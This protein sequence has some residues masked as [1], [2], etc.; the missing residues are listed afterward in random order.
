M[1]PD[2][3]VCAREVS[4]V[5]FANGWVARKHGNV[6][7]YYGASDAS[8]HVATST[9]DKLLDYVLNTPADGMR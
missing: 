8:T 1:A 5:L 9:V 2:S 7:I 4:N 6:F 3:E